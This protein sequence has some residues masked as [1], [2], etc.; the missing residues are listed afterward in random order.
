VGVV[1]AV[2]EHLEGTPRLGYRDYPEASS[3]PS[4]GWAFVDR[5]CLRTNL[6]IDV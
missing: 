4:A 6:I 1:L 3:R 5:I 2:D